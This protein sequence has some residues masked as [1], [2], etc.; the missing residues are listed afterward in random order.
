MGQSMNDTLD[1][2]LD[3]V[4]PLSL[5]RVGLQSKVAGSS[6]PAEAA[7]TPQKANGA[8]LTSAIQKTLLE[9]RTCKAM[10]NEIYPDDLFEG[11]RLLGSKEENSL[12]AE[13]A[14]KPEKATG[15]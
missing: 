2:S 10:I 5:P 11:P 6:L 1:G 3:E 7:A 9:K 8:K 14:A 15:A 12:P 13:A 4:S